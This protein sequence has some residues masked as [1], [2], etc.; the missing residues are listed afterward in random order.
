MMRLLGMRGEAFIGFDSTLLKP[1]RKG[2]SA[3][4]SHTSAGWRYFLC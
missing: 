4:P 2:D 1:L 3:Y